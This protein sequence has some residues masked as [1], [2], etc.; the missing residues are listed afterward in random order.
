MSTHPIYLPGAE[1]VDFTDPNNSFRWA[2]VT[3]AY[4][5]PLRIRLDGDTTELPLTPDVLDRP[6]M[7]S[8]GSRVWVQLNGRRVI[9]IG[10]A[11]AGV[12]VELGAGVDLDTITVPGTYTQSASAE[13]SGGTNYPAGVAGLLEVYINDNNM[14]WQRYTPYGNYSN[15]FYMRASYNGT[16]STWSHFY[17]DTGDDT[18]WVAASTA[19]FAGSYSSLTGGVVRRRNGV[20]GIQLTGVL[21]G[22]LDN[23]NRNLWTMP[24]DWTPAQSNGSIGAGPSAA[25]WQGYASTGGTIASVN[26]FATIATGSTIQA[27]GTYLL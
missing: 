25:G 7:Y 21:S 10:R 13:A 6:Q 1:H 24:S 26:V 3:Q 5:N 23:T 19:G 17:G 20:V 22:A 11:N 27:M 16:W 4:P 15:T 8:V 12:M 18:G 9:I 14:V 2:T